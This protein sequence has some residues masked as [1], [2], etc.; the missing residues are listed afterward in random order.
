MSDPGA[1]VRALLDTARLSVS[2]DE[3]AAFVAIYPCLRSRT[4]RLYQPFLE[5]EEPALRFDPT[6]E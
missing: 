1:T 6:A 2:A 4:D 5:A 3:L